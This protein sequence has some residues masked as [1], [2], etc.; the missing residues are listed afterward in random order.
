MS[1]EDQPVRLPIVL[2]ALLVLAGC[3]KAPEDPLCRYEP[4]PATMDLPS[5]QGAVRIT[6]T[7][8]EY[9]YVFDDSGKQ[10]TYAR[11]NQSATVKPGRYQVKVNKSTHPVTVQAKI[12]TTCA[13][14]SILASGTTDEYFY[15]FDGSNNQMAYQKI[16]KALAFF[17]GKY[18][19]QVNK[20]PA[21]VDVAAGSTAELKPANLTVEAGTDEYFYVFDSSGAQLAYNKLS[22]SLALLPGAWTVRV[23]GTSQAVNA[24]AGDAL[25]VPAGMLVVNGATDEYYYVFNSAGTQLA[26]NKLG[27]PLAFLPGSYT[28][29]VNNTALPV[30]LEGAKT[31]EY[32]TGA[33]TVN[34]NKD[35]YYYV[36]DANGTQLGYKKLNEPIA[37]FAGSYSVK[38]DQ[39][40]RPASITAGQ[41]NVMNW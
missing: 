31:A 2:G 37:L 33:L 25:R 16:G 17:P 26:Y 39:A 41:T 9:F 34:G 21:P 12:L 28:A 40:T 4:A 5:G 6:G 35:A 10:L 1:R 15:V 38:V 11:L 24:T 19:V 3:S 23:N 18:Q 7:T 32:S 14:G 30:Q 27:R 20:T 22:K 36:F 8:E 13:T 29:K